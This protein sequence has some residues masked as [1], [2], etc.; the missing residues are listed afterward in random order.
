M[1]DSRARLKQEMRQ[2]IPQQKV[3]CWNTN[4]DERIGTHTGMARIM[5]ITVKKEFKKKARVV[6]HS[7]GLRTTSFRK[8]KSE[9]KIGDICIFL[10]R[11]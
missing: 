9:I 5:K 11:E 1:L 3:L 10:R 2:E 4:N 7:Q 8:T 6:G